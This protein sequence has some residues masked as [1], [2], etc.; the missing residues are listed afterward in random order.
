MLSV[1]HSIP[2]FRNVCSRTLSVI[3][4]K[5]QINFSVSI[6]SNTQNAIVAVGDEINIQNINRMASATALLL[7]VVAFFPFENSLGRP[8]GK[9][10][11]KVRL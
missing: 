1:V 7:C 2:V 3:N 8:S 6:Y 4:P 9:L 11:L 5:A 10:R